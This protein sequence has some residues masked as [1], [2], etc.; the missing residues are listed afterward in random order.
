MPKFSTFTGLQPLWDIWD[1]GSRTQ[2]SL[3]QLEDR[4]LEEE[5][6]SKWRADPLGDTAKN[7]G[8]RWWDLPL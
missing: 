8:K 3:R 6:G 5:Q 2:P 7:H 1:K 4:Q